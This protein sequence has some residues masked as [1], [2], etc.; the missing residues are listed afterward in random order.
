MRHD[1][2]FILVCSALFLIGG[3]LRLATGGLNLPWSLCWGFAVI[4]GLG[5]WH[6]SGTSPP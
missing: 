6:R 4:N 5:R 3:A 1:L 2:R